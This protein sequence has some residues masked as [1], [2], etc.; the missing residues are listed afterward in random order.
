STIGSPGAAQAAL[1]VGALDKADQL[2]NF[3]SR[4]PRVGDSVIKPDIVAPG[5]DIVAARAAGTTIPNAK[6]V[7]EHYTTVSGTSMAAPHVAGAAAI[8]AQQHPQWSGEQIKSALTSTA[9]DAGYSP[10][11]Q[12]AGRVDVARV[13]DQQVFATTAADFGSREWPHDAGT[14]TRTVTYR[15]L[16][17]TPT[18]LDLSLSATGQDGEPAP[19]GLLELSAESLTVPADGTADV[20]VRLTESRDVV[21]V[22]GGHVTATD[23]AGAVVTTSVGVQMKPETFTV[24]VARYDL[25][26]PTTDNCTSAVF[27]VPAGTYMIDTG[28]LPDYYDAH[29]RPTS[30]VGVL[31]EVVVTADTE[32]T[33][34]LNAAK[35]LE[36]DTPQPSEAGMKMVGFNRVTADGYT[37]NS[38]S[39]SVPW[40]N[41]VAIPT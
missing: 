17:T 31:P 40:I 33:I 28:G 11:E 19:A 22:F 24:Q 16:A 8:V 26:V 21:G 12:G 14:A 36:V 37:F 18:T 9:H 5:V 13:V 7:G 3:S 23:G 4:G 6:H 38:F 41:H 29:G 27:D 35:P 34:D 20:Q 39:V 10:Y 2:A 1:T 30:V 25:A 15:N 32:L